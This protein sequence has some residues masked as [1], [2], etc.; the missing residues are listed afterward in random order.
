M[1]AAQIPETLRREI[2][3]LEE[4]GAAEQNSDR[5]C[6]AEQTVARISGMSDRFGITRLADVTGLDCIGIPVWMA[7]RPNSRTLAV[8]QGKGLS[9][10]AAQA[11]AL[12][13]AAEIATAEAVPGSSRVCSLRDLVAAGARAMPLNHLRARGEQPLAETEAIDWVE[14]FDILRN[15]LVWVPAEAAMVAPASERRRSSYWQSSDGLASGNILLEA[16][17]HGLC[18]RIER[19]AIVLWQLQPDTFVLKRGIAPASFVNAEIDALVGLIERADLALHLFDITSDVNI[20]VFFALISRKPDGRE[21]LW[22]HFD[23]S[24]G[25]GCH[26]SPARAVIRAITEAAQSRVTSITGARDDFDPNLYGAPLKGDLT[27]YLSAP[28]KRMERPPQESEHRPARNLAVM[29]DA[30][31]SVNVESVVAVPLA[32][33]DGFAVVKVLVPELEHPAGN[34]LQRFGRRALSMM[35]AAR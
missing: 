9:C 17:V 21:R 16:A 18:E 1:K 14:G 19:D 26:P 22:K 27:L 2:A 30:L 32:T 10:A 28:Q 11:S 15:H 34:R 33:E 24:G 3:L 6:R 25:Y 31:Q 7:V 35:M 20:P 23:L 12:M 5:L 13:E 29:L 8:S 4:R